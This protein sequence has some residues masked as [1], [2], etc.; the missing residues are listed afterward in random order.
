MPFDEYPSCFPLTIMVRAYN[1]FSQRFVSYVTQTVEMTV[2]R[3]KLRFF[4]LVTLEAAGA[5]I[6]A[7]G[8]TS[9]LDA[10]ALKVSVEPATRCNH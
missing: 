6:C 3:K 8:L 9:L 10:H 2:R 1:G 5:D 7:N 4:D